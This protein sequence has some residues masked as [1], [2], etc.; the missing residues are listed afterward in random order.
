MGVLVWSENTHFVFL[1]TTADFVK[2]KN[3]NQE[4]YFFFF[5][6]QEGYYDI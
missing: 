5:Y 4:G 2:N 6:N 1:T 3:K